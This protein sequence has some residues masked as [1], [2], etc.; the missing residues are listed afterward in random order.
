MMR[1]VK[2]AYLKRKWHSRWEQQH[3]ER[4]RFLEEK[5]LWSN[6]VKNILEVNSKAFKSCCQF[7]FQV[8]HWGAD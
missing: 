2:Y 3:S 5:A 6:T 7:R 8:E 4:Q 1:R